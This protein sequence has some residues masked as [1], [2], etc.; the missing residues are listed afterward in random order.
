MQ[1]QL[2]ILRRYPLFRA[3]SGAQW[4]ALVGHI[5]LQMLEARQTLFCEG[6]AATAFYFVSVGAIR[7]F[8]PSVRRGGY[9]RITRGGECLAECVLFAQPLRYRTSAVAVER[10]TLFVIRRDVY[11]QFLQESFEVYRCVLGVLNA[12]LNAYRD[13]AENLACHS[14]QVRVARYLLDLLANGNAT[15]LRLPMQKNEIAV[16]LGL[17]PETLSRVLRV[18]RERKVLEVAGSTVIV[19]NDHALEAIACH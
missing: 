19:H 13:Q 10:S 7:C 8:H 14:S 18:F 4:A 1:L 12:R 9:E 5:D 3:L 16:R 6:D 17:A 15:R 2:N 11:L